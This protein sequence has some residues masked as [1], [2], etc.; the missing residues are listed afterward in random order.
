MKISELKKLVNELPDNIDDK[1]VV[2]RE[3]GK[4]KESNNWFKKDSL[5][6]LAYFDEDTDELAFCDEKSYKEHKEIENSNLNENKFMNFSEF[7]N[8]SKV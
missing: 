7:E 4:M 5:I 1:D 8:N 6:W 2:I 3:I